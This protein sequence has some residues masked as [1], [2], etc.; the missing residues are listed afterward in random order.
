M[1]PSLT[2]QIFIRSC[3]FH[4]AVVVWFSA[5]VFLLPGILLAPRRLVKRGFDL[6]ILGYL[7]LLKHICGQTY[8]LRGRQNIPAGPVLFASKHLSKWDSAVL[9]I[10]LGDPAVVLRREMLWFPLYGCVIMRLRHLAV[11]R[12]ANVAAAAHLVRNAKSRIKEGRSVLIFPE[13][14]R[15][16]VLPFPPPAY[17]RGVTALY[18]LL[19]IPCVP[20]AVNSG[21]F[22]PRDTLMRYPGTI[23]AE[24]LPPIEPGL[25]SSEF[26]R[27]LIY[28]LETNSQRLVCEGLAASTAGLS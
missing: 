3:L 23:V 10:L 14:T 11:P 17:K 24:I 20:I 13:G 25:D 6:T 19:H 12:S 16:P 9:P 28:Q 21:L 26:T 18:K 15:A 7:G 4:A 27:E 8:E 5:C 1:P 22:W 2:P